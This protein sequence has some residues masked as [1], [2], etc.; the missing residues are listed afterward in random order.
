MSG[1]RRPLRNVLLG[2]C[3]VAVLVS[4]VPVFIAFATSKITFIKLF[5]VGLAMRR[6]L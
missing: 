3:V 4:L 2:A 6:A 1:A 5:G